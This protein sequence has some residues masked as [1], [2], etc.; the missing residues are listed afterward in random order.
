MLGS[1]E[2]ERG[3]KDAHTEAFPSRGAHGKQ[4]ARLESRMRKGRFQSQRMKRKKT[5]RNRS[6]EEAD[7]DEMV[8]L[9]IRLLGE[10][11]RSL[12]IRGESDDLC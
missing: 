4:T 10:R 12:S 6:R 11:F 2:S 8:R 7:L 3:G 1:D 9:F 5:E